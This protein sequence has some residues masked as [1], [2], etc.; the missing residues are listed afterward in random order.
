MI[1]S[2][3]AFEYGPTAPANV[4]DLSAPPCQL[5]TEILLKKTSTISEQRKIDQAFSEKFKGYIDLSMF[6]THYFTSK[7]HTISRNS[8]FH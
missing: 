5:K 4:G 8:L 1:F 3:Q 6:D 7:T 2:H